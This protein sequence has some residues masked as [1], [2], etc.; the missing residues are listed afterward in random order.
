VIVDGE[1]R[2]FHLPLRAPLETGA[3]RIVAREGALLV[4]R[5]AAGR[6][7]FGEASPIPG[8]RA[9]AREPVDAVLAVLGKAARSLAGRS[10]D[11]VADVLAGVGSEHPASRFAIETA[12]ADLVSQALGM[13]MADWLAGGAA[14][15]EQVAVNALIAGGSAE[16]VRDAAEKARADGF[17]AFKLKLGVRGIGEDTKRVAALRDAVGRDGVIRLDA[18]GAWSPEEAAAALA[19]FARFEVDYVEDPIRIR[20]PDHVA[21]LAAL[22]QI[23][24]RIPLAIDDAA[25]DPV[26]LRRAIDLRAADVLVVKPSCLGGLGATTA[27][28]N[29]ARE[30][31]MRAV[32]TSGIDS[33]VGLAA[34]LQLAASLPGELP[35][36]GLATSHLLAR[37]VAPPPPIVNGAMALPQMSGL[38]V[39]PDGRPT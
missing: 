33:A 3:S 32:V 12:C 27:I 37:D 10:P 36:C 20:T 11:D 14:P 4:L 16:A 19:E 18:N 7:G 13:R 6:V 21:E 35:P 1:V 23:T 25:A 24:T 15:R 9:F 22:R 26:L 30:G 28:V 38:G 29:D 8:F 31:G 39:A 5:G 2:P 17:R 34:T